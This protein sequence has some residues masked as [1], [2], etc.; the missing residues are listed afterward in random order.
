MDKVN[1]EQL[2][3]SFKDFLS[4]QQALADLTIRNYI[5]DLNSLFEFMRIKNLSEMNSLNKVVI[6]DYLSWLTQLGYVRS[7]LVRKQSGLRVFLKWMLN[8]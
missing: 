6:R 1:R 2:I 7:S 3:E 8:P 4:E 5:S